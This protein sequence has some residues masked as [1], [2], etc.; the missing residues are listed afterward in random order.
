MN[1]RRQIYGT[2]ASVSGL[3]SPIQSK[4]RSLDHNL[5]PLL[6]GRSGKVLDIG[7]G[8]GEF[9]ELCD[10]LGLEAEGVEINAELVDASRSRG[11]KVVLIDDL[12]TFLKSCSRSYDV[13]SMID[14]LEHFTKAEA[15]EIVSLVC[16]HALHSGGILVLQ[17]PNMQS[18]F[19][20]LNLYHDLTHE[21]GY[22]EFSLN[23][24]LRA[25]GFKKVLT[26]PQN[27][28][29]SG[30]YIVRRVL[31]RILYILFRAILLVDQ[32]NRGRV[33]TPNLIAVAGF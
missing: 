2:Y 24:L 28:P 10:H 7:S 25:A 8:Q 33:L 4:Y 26:Y 6:G 13:V 11:L 3:H 14:V 20:T 19:A 16:R 17:V 29:M 32:P 1:Y 21:W 18:P 5:A 30:L 9:L 23:Q 22:T 31:R 15:F 27:Y 12:A